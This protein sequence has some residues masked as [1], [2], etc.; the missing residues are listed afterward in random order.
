MRGAERTIALLDA[1]SLSSSRIAANRHAT[2]KGTHGGLIRSALAWNGEI[3]SPPTNPSRAQELDVN[4]SAE[5]A[6]SPDVT[7]YQV[8]DLIIDI[9]LQRVTRGDIEIPLPALSFEL[10]LALTRAAPNLVTYDQLMERVWAGV[11]V[12]PETVTQRIKL[13][14]D[15]LGR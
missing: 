3:E 13:V 8:D 5:T 2:L 9:G 6:P 7:G 1:A 14:R 4:R 15:A 12:N 11:V 10:L